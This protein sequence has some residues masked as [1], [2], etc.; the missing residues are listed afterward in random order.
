MVTIVM[1]VF[2]DISRTE[3]NSAL[4]FHMDYEKNMSNTKIS[5]SMKKSWENGTELL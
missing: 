4:K 3:H 1:P 2:A 5:K